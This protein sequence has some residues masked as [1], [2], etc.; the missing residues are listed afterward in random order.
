MKHA[1]HVRAYNCCLVSML[2]GLKSHDLR[3][4]SSA[5]RGADFCK[6]DGLLNSPQKQTSRRPVDLPSLTSVKD[7]KHL[8]WSWDKR[9]KKK[10]LFQHN[11]LTDCWLLSTRRVS[12]STSCCRVAEIFFLEK[13]CRTLFSFRLF[14]I[15]PEKIYCTPRTDRSRSKTTTASGRHVSCLPAQAS[16]FPF[17]RPLPF[18]RNEFLVS[19]IRHKSL[20]RKEETFF[21]SRSDVHSNLLFSLFFSS[22]RRKRIE[23]KKK[24][25]KTETDGRTESIHFFLSESAAQLWMVGKGR[26]RKIRS[27]KSFHPPKKRKKNFSIPSYWSQATSVGWETFQ[28]LPWCCS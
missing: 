9:T 3:S 7:R 1:I 16:I 15:G 6:L 14:S 25:L 13:I 17:F 23:K 2:I 26:S 22:Q 27:A 19:W 5:Y 28:G 12:K 11:Q 8:V 24:G 18:L 21:S 10:N 4:Y 20:E